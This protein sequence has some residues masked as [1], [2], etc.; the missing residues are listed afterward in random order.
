MIPDL[1]HPVLL[2]AT[3][4]KPSSS[5]GSIFWIF[6][7]VIA[8]AGYFFWLRPQQQRQRKQRAAQTDIA[9]GDEVVTVGGIVGRVIEMEE[10]RVH[11]LTGH[12]TTAGA[13]EHLP[14]RMTF[15]RSAISRKVEPA[16]PEPATNG[17]GEVGDFSFEHDEDDEDEVAGYDEG[18]DDAL[19]ATAEADAGGW[20]EDGADDADPEHPA[21]GNGSGGGPTPRRSGRGR[22]AG[23]GAKGGTSP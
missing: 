11:L 22:R 16:T 6:L 13:N 12:H 3:K 10:D 15:V 18:A 23:G 20:A 4:S 17:S 7:L 8:V 14:H 19:E 21:G 9:E 2:A 5:S 1:L